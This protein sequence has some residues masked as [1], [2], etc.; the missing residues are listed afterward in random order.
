[1]IKNKLSSKFKNDVGMMEEELV[2]ITFEFWPHPVCF[3][4]YA[5]LK[6]WSIYFHYLICANFYWAHYVP[7]CS[8][9]WASHSIAKVCMQM[10][11]SNNCFLQREAAKSGSERVLWYSSKTFSVL[12]LLHQLVAIAIYSSVR[13]LPWGRNASC[14][15]VTYS[16]TWGKWCARELAGAV[17]SCRNDRVKGE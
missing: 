11:V 13:A 8:L 10:P 3:A 4:Y 17:R 15:T 7:R 16:I 6:R 12:R 2:Q 9:P 5:D 1:M 14:N